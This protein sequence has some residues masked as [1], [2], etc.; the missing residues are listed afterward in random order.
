ML[1]VTVYNNQ[2]G[3]TLPDELLETFS[4]SATAAL[5]DVLANTVNGGGV[6]GELEEIEVSIVS[7]EVIDQVHQDFMDVE[8]A[9]DV[10]T[11]A[12][13]EIVISADTA[14]RLS[15][16]YNQSLE[17]ELFLY[18]IHG[19]LHLAGHEDHDADEREAMEKI[20]FDLVE[21]YWI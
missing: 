4:V 20:Q 10:I 13:G 19:L 14:L 3:I 11:F 8:G 17:K 9:T 16:D 15:S 5:P 21:K 6:I 18:I 12:H 1:E 7:D 2:T